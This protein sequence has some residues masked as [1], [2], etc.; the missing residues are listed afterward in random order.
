M[1]RPYTQ[2]LQRDFGERTHVYPTYIQLTLPV[3]FITPTELQS[4]VSYIPTYLPNYQPAYYQV[5]IEYVDS[6]L[7]DYAN[8]NVTLHEQKI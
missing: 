4:T 3:R 2:D 6:G 7:A 8:K 5:R 1:D